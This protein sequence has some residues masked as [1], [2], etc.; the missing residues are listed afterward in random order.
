MARETSDRSGPRHE[1]VL[2]EGPLCFFQ[3]NET[4]PRVV[5][6]EVQALIKEAAKRDTGLMGVFN[7][8][9]LHF[10]SKEKNV[11][12]PRQ[13]IQTFFP[14]GSWTKPFRQLARG[15]GEG[16]SEHFL[17]K[18]PEQF[19]AD[20]DAA[21]EAAG[22]DPEREIWEVQ[23]ARGASAVYN[24]KVVQAYVLL[25]TQGYNHYKDLTA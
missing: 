25:R 11:G 4:D 9:F 12:I 6:A 15:A 21:A 7:N 2:P 19:Y 5:N 13:A 8:F 20:V 1:I 10:A 17:N 14:E 22:I 16:N 18:T 24:D 3:S 23:K